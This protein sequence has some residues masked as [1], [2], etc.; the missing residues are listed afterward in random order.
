MRPIKIYT[1]SK[2]IHAAKLKAL[3]PPDFHFN[4]RWL[5]TA[6]LSAN[7]TRLAAKW[8]IENFGD[9]RECDYILVY[10]EKGDVLQGA[11]GEAFYGMAYGKPVYI[12]M[13]FSDI[14]PN[15]WMLMGENSVHPVMRR[16]KV[17]E[18]LEE[19]R[20]QH[21]PKEEKIGW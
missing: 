10:G 4:A 1:A 8:Q 12:V 11:I 13:D 19:L 18:V 14:V 15:P 20:R 3:E 17:E 16:G 21:K 5:D 2:L 6:N 7:S 9:I